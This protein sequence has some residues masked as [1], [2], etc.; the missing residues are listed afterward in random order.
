MIILISALGI[1]IHVGS[2]LLTLNQVD[3]D[4]RECNDDPV[5]IIQA[6]Y[7]HGHGDIA[8]HC[9]NHCMSWYDPSKVEPHPSMDTMVK[10]F[11]D[12]KNDSARSI[13]FQHQYP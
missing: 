8:E 3:R 12:M 5:C 13:S 4:M 2:Y 11:T 1:F 10:F 9:F 6:L 7:R